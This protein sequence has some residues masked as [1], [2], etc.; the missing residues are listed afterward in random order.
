MKAAFI[1]FGGSDCYPV[2]GFGDFQSSHSSL[3]E[4]MV[5]AVTSDTLEW[6]H[7]GRVDDDGFIA[8]V[9]RRSLDGHNGEYPFP[10]TD[11]EE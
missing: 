6:W 7:V 5:A 3:D 1:L 8:V 2:G 11:Q 4:A 10:A 9:R